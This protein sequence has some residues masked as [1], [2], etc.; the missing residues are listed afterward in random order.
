MTH[1]TVTHD[2]RHIDTEQTFLA[3]LY[4]LII[5]RYDRAR[6]HFNGIDILCL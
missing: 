3:T 5:G 1:G 6:A 4:P 2:T